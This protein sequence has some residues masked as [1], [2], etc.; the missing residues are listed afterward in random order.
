M[1][2]IIIDGRDLTIEDVVNVS[3]NGY[4]V[5]L[6]KEALKKVKL[7]RDLVDKFVDEQKVVYG[8]TTGFGKFSDVTISKEETHNLQ[9]NL[10][11]S[12]ACGIGK[13]FEEDIVRAIML[14]RV[15]NLSK[16]YSGVRIE[17]LNTLVNM[18][19]NNVCP[20]FWKKD[21]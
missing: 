2:K 19:N 15:N 16:G 17:T 20:V 7:S 12:H 21:H 14:L 10:I 8:I 6:G 5:E 11:I 9:R 3:R 18:L 13:P 1:N 4:K